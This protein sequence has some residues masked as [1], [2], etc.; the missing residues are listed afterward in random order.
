MKTF[1][2]SSTFRDMHLERDIIHKRVSPM[3]NEI[4]RQYGDTVEFCDLRWGVNT[5]D[6]D[7][8]TGS[9]KVLSVCLD[10]IDR[11]S[12]YMIVIVG[13]RYG[14]IPNKELMQEA[15]IQHG[16]AEINRLKMSVTALEIEYGALSSKEKLANTL[17][18]FREMS[19]NVP[20]DYR[21][22]NVWYFR[23]L[24]KLKKRIIKLSNGN[25][26]FYKTAWNE[27]KQSLDG[28][29]AFSEMLFYDIRNLLI[30]D[31]QIYS[32][33]TEYERDI[34]I[35]WEYARQKSQ[36]FSAR[37]TIV[38]ELKDL[39]NKGT[40]LISVRGTSGSGK[41][42]LVG[43]LAI[44]L[45]KEN[46]HVFPVFCG[47]TSLSNDVVDIVKYMIYCLE[48]L[49][50]RKS[51]FSTKNSF[52]EG[53]DSLSQKLYKLIDE[54]RKN[55]PDSK[56]V[57]L[58]DALDQLMGSADDTLSFIT[59][60]LDGSVQMV[61]S[62]LN[63]F[64]LKKEGYV[65]SIVGLS[66]EEIP[67]AIRGILKT[68]GLDANVINAIIE[69]KSSDNPLY[70]SLLVRR[71]ELMEKS[72]YD[73]IARLGGDGAAISKLQMEIVNN[74]SD[75]TDTL[76]ADILDIA[77]TR[78]GGNIV[79][80]AAEYIA[81]SRRG[82]R[83]GDLE[84]LFYIDNVEW[85]QIE[86]SMFIQY[87][88]D[89]FVVL[90]DGRIGFSHKSI[91]AGVLNRIKNKEELY[92]NL[93]DHFS[94]LSANDVVRM[95]DLLYYAQRVQDKKYI[96]DYINE[97]YSQKD[98]IS[99]A[100][101]TVA[102]LM[103]E[104]YD[105]WW[106]KLIENA[107]EYGVVENT[108]VNHNVLADFINIYL[109]GEFTKDHRFVD[110][111]VRHANYTLAKKL[112]SKNTTPD[113]ALTLFS[114]TIKYGELFLNT[115]NADDLW[116]AKALFDEAIGL[117][118]NTIGKL[119][120]EDGDGLLLEFVSA[121]SNLAKCFFQMASKDDSAQYYEKTKEAYLTGIHL[122]ED[123][124]NLSSEEEQ[125]ALAY[126]CFYLGQCYKH[127][128]SPSYHENEELWL[129]T[130]DIIEGMS[131]AVHEFRKTELLIAT[132]GELGMLYW[133]GGEIN[134][135][136]QK[137][138]D[139]FGKVIA[140]YN[141][142]EHR[143]SDEERHSFR[144]N[145]SVSLCRLAAILFNKGGNVERAYSLA[146]KA[147]EESR[148]AH[149]SDPSVATIYYLF[150]SCKVMSAICA[151]RGGEYTQ[152][153]RATAV[154]MLRILQ[155][156]ADNSLDFRS[157]QLYSDAL[158]A[159]ALGGLSTKEEKMDSLVRAE[160]T[161]KKMF[162]IKKDSAYLVKSE[163]CRMKYAELQSGQEGQSNELHIAALSYQ[164]GDFKSA[165]EL[166][167]KLA[168]AGNASAQT[169]LGVMYILGQYVPQSAQRALYWLEK[170]ANQ[171]VEVAQT[172]ISK[173]KAEETANNNKGLFDEALSLYKAGMLKEAL[174][175]F[176]ALAEQGHVMSQFIVGNMYD[177]GESVPRDYKQAFIWYKKAAEQGH[178]D[179]E[180]NL[181]V[182]YADG[183]GTE[184]DYE[185]AIEWFSKSANRG[186]QKAQQEVLTLSH[187]LAERYNEEAFQAFDAQRISDAIKL[188]ELSGKYGNTNAYL[189]L[190]IMFIQ[191]KVVEKNVLKAKEYLSKAMER[192]NAQAKQIYDM[193]I[194]E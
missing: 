84:K 16:V 105:L 143:F 3:V 62:H 154:E 65:Y 92:K 4:S 139:Y 122:L 148:K 116:H 173:L 30:K 185:K 57:F 188:F 144:I 189:N 44:E 134:D 186:N 67:L 106:E 6:L 7:S 45:S 13:E 2:V 123:N 172:Y 181:A 147:I 184:Q 75:D 58:I 79:K 76:C 37:Y 118:K 155:P 167:E 31:W 149:L 135:N 78:I 145:Y 33:L 182:F 42:T 51:D 131:L 117:W 190:G 91:K 63:E 59:D 9:R 68:R 72:E 120:F 60:N 179:A 69:K 159:F 55:C 25:V 161:L 15:I 166:F 85:N 66:K 96:L 50:G 82:L 176:K 5:G 162:S 39:L 94:S 34:K 128:Y 136:T 23:Q 109:I 70:L 121:Y 193:I 191:G 133:G 174:E 104:D 47:L 100:A 52:E 129:R 156:L 180:Y 169:N 14:W 101:K 32:R 110:I 56:V 1:F 125:F 151:K 95:Q 87:L 88:Q 158:I 48:S 18:Y 140:Y 175:I 71:F 22:E 80:R 97:Y 127:L 164:K 93:F 73:A 119:T 99:C 64:V 150:D 114:C 126:M 112:Y 192:G 8:D 165:F 35:Q 170:A 171:G 132:Y 103:K 61:V 40:P 98:I 178:P 194:N 29:D 20:D 12:P 53:N 141:Q 177:F 124:R 24:K 26:R 152:E 138:E 157:M 142:N 17:F 90:D 74:S 168:I 137:A 146:K 130:V 38:K 46:N 183:K 89:F 19:G 153:A 107:D 41:S 28:L 81:V 111:H 163:Q 11:C 86:F 113:Y 36:V 27:D 83:P 108:L 21:S 77:S 43:Q 54:Y 160:K 115:N 10:E 102:Q 49:H 187:E